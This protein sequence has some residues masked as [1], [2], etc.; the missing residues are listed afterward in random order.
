[1]SWDLGF[2]TEVFKWKF[3]MYSGDCS[4]SDFDKRCSL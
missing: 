2:S 1:M 3:D 4:L